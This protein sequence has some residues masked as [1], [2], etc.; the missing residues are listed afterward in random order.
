MP[1]IVLL[2]AA[3]SAFLVIS[4][5]LY[6]LVSP[7]KLQQEGLIFPSKEKEP[8][9]VH[10]YVVRRKIS[11]ITLF[12]AGGIFVAKLSLIALVS[13]FLLGGQSLLAATQDW[14]FNTSGEYTYNE[15]K[16][17]VT[18]GAAQLVDQ[19]GGG[20]CD[21]TANACTTFVSSPTC[22]A[23]AGCAWGGDASGATTNPSFD[24]GTTGWTYVDW[25]QGNR[26]SGTRVTSGGNPNAYVNIALATQ[27]K[28]TASGYWRQAFTTTEANPTAS[29]NFDWKITSYSD[30][31]LTSYIIY[32]FVDSASGAPTI[33]NHVWSQTITS[34]T[35]WA[36]VTDLDVSSK[37]S[38]A[39]TYY[40]KIVARRITGLG[41]SGTQ[42]VGFDNVQ[43]NWSKSAACSGTATACNAYSTSSTCSTQAG[44]DWTPVPVYPTDSPSITPT[45]SLAPVGVTG[46]NSF[47]ETAT[48]NGGEINYQLSSDDGATWKYWNNSAWETAST[49]ANANPYNI[50]NANIPS[51]TTTDSKIT[52]KAFLVSNGTQQ[53]ILDNVA[54]GYTQNAIPVVQTV[55]ATQNTTSGYVNVSYN[56]KD[57]NSDPNNLVNYEYSLTGAFTGEQVTMTPVPS[58]PDHSGITGLTTS[59]SGVSHTFVWDAEND[60]GSV[61]ASNVYVRIR[62]NDGI[63]DSNYLSSSS[64]GVDYVLPVIDSLTASQVSASTNVQ[65]NYNLT[66]NTSPAILVELEISSDSGSSWT[67][68]A[69]SVT[70]DVGANVSTGNDKSIVW[71]AGTDFAN[72]EN[73]IMMVRLRA[74]DRYQNQSNYLSSSSF[75]VDNRAPV[76]ATPTNLLAQPL[77]GADAVLVGG[78]FNEGNPNTNN[79][80]VAINGGAYSAAQAGDTNTATPSDKSLSVGTTLKGND[81]VSSVKIEHTDDFNQMTSNENL[82]PTSAYQFVKPYTPPA[83]TVSNPGETSLDVTITKHAD[84]AND[85][86]YTILE[87]TQNLYVQSD[88][89]LGSEAYWQSVGLKNVTSLSQPISQYS[90]KV[91]SRNPSD[92]GHATSSESDLSS[93]ASSDYQS[94]VIAINSVSQTTDGTKYVVINYTGTD[95]QNTANNLVK[96]EYSVNNTEWQ[97]M[98]EKSGVNSSGTTNLAFTNSGAG[99]VFAWDVATD[100]PNT[101]DSSVYV[102]LESNNAISNSNI[103]TSSAFLVNTVGPIASNLQ[104]LQT[105]ATNNVVITYDLVDG[106]DTTNSVALSISSDSGVTYNVTTTGATGDIGNNITAGLARQITWNAGTNFADQEKNTMRVKLV[107]INSLG[108]EGSPVES[109]DFVVDTKAPIVS[110]VVAT[111][112]SGSALV[113]ITYTLADLSNADVEFEVSSNS[114]GSWT[115]PNSTYTGDMGA[116]Q[117]PGSKTFNWNAVV[118]FPDQELSTMKIRIRA[119]DLFNHQSAYDASADFS[120][121]TKVLSISDITAAQNLETQLFTIRYDLNKTATISLEIS[122]DGGV[123]WVVPTSTATGHLGADISAGNNKTISWNAGLDYGNE[124]KTSMRVRLQGTDS[125][126][127]VSPWYESSDFSLDTAAPLGLLYLSKFASTASSVTLNW[128]SGVADAN[129]HHY[130]LWHGSNQADVINRTGTAQK[131][132]VNNDAALSSETS[133]STVITGISLTDNYYVKIWAID[134]YTNEA[135]IAELNVYTAPL[136]FALEIQNPIGSGS[137]SPIIGSHNYNQGDSASVSAS[138]APNWNFDYWILDGANSGSANPIT[139]AMNANHTLKAVFT[140]NPPTVYSLTVEAPTGNGTTDPATGS[141]DYNEGTNAQISASAASGWAFDHWLLGGLNVG[142]SNPLTVLMDGNHTVKAVF[143]EVIIPPTVYSLTIEAPTGSGTTNPA[144]GSQNYNEG[145]NAQIFATAASGWTF[146][147]WL[148]DNVSS[149]AANPFTVLMNTNH[150]LKAVF[151]ETV[152]P[153]TDTARRSIAIDTTAPE[154]PILTPVQT[155]TNIT[156]ISISGLAEPGA[157]IL[158]YDGDTLVGDFD[159]LVGD[160]GRF[161]QT[162]TFSPGN[163]ILTVKAVDASNNVSASS[164]PIELTIITQ[165]QEALI[166]LSPQNNSQI[167]DANP[168]LIGVSS[169]SAKIDINLDQRRIFTV[170]A[171]NDGAWQFKIPSDFSLENG[172]HTIIF[173][174]TD[175]AGNKSP[176]ITWTLNKVVAVEE[177]IPEPVVT[178]TVTAPVSTPVSTPASRPAPVRRVV[179]PRRETITRAPAELVRENVSA[180]ELAGFPVPEINSVNSAIE[181]NTTTNTNADLFTFS[182]KALPK[183]DVLV[184]IHSDQALIYRTKA[185]DKGIWAMSHSQADVQLTPGQHSV[186]AVAIDPTAKVKSKP[187]AVSTFTVEKNFWASLFANLNLKTTVVSLAII[188]LAMFWLYRIKKAEKKPRA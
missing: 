113:V 101:Q 114:G 188:L 135:T 61:Y 30:A 33:G 85:L 54:I 139:I 4:F 173:I 185:N 175:L 149:G 183:Q 86:E 163:H 55:S 111:Q 106:A 100:L 92:G 138:A 37:I 21:G 64:F 69:T 142:S 82:S 67:V 52:W 77:A 126:G 112:S 47:S 147:R 2:V 165:T 81:Y 32:V 10:V 15:A 180:L 123:S 57:D 134:D 88:G 83:P 145:D 6:L 59:A 71:Q 75:I 23:Q 116:S 26:A 162:F 29:V 39:G 66:E 17:A 84:E 68:P 80:Y 22:T 125:L 7:K 98:T 120:I 65:I 43:L 170:T 20:S 40:I 129:F 63:A 140:E 94:Q 177:V 160:N 53:I 44:C 34:T 109:A 148:L 128:S 124:E 87:T 127:I 11:L 186:Y 50:I 70:G 48:K 90:F 118:D 89:S 105:P 108:N 56:L 110:D 131:W 155:P 74:K 178:P 42:T 130:E 19:G 184:Y 153:V 117:T 72:Q 91:K 14:N 115:V 62:S 38:T 132:S 9:H 150:T 36:S 46:W 133:N 182:G 176:E 102:R 13:T 107:A 58:D 99:L 5:P 27:S 96:Y 156:S 16:I 8:T 136:T 24:S 166:V 95:F 35:N 179:A 159:R 18:G 167:T 60:L 151:I 152:V 76:I 45:T 28:N 122:A 41:A 104:V 158:L 73:N 1:Y 31:G 144:T 157:K 119:T 103:A 93:G 143:T 3:E 79:F 97:T 161:V 164:D 25:E 172:S 146:D 137:T 78:S 154:K 49:S 174:A 168:I 187:S 121:N 12:S 169:P 51:F 181:T 171:N 141:Y